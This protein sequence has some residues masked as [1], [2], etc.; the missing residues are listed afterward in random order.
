MAAPVKRV[1]VLKAGAEAVG[2]THGG[3]EYVAFRIP[4]LVAAGNNTLVAFAEARKFA[5]SDWG[6]GQGQGQHDW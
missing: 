6:R 5:N 3:C 2:C 1:T 4:D